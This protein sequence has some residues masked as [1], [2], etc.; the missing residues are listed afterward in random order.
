MQ[1]TGKVTAFMLETAYVWFRDC[2]AAYF[3]AREEQL[4]PSAKI[5]AERD[6]AI[7]ALLHWKKLYESEVG[8][9]FDWPREAVAHAQAHYLAGVTS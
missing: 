9:K 1:G 7:T 5:V 6:E 4:I 2:D 8:R 3:S